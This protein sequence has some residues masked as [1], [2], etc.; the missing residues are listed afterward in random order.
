MANAKYDSATIQ[1]PPAALTRPP[2]HPSGNSWQPLAALAIVPVVILEASRLGMRAASSVSLVIFKALKSGMRSRLNIPEP[3]LVAGKKG[4]S[5][6][7]QVSAVL[8]KLFDK[9]PV[10]ILLA[11][12]KFG[13]S[14]GCKSRLP[15]E[16]LPVSFVVARLGASHLSSQV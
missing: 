12:F 11:L 16:M 9:V 10:V 15:D 5:S 14:E 7:C 1:H 2:D 3:I 4:I 8:T 6:R 13:M